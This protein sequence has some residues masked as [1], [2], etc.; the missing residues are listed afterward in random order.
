MSVLAL[1]NE[2]I[3]EYCTVNERMD[4]W[5]KYGLWMNQWVNESTSSCYSMSGSG[6]G[7]GACQFFDW[8][9]ATG[10]EGDLESFFSFYREACLLYFVDGVLYCCNCAAACALLTVL[11]HAFWN[12]LHGSCLSGWMQLGVLQRSLKSRIQGSNSIMWLGHTLRESTVHVWFQV[13]G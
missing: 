7:C 2:G 5:T 10:S 1:W 12:H 3:D 9:T 13:P 8:A 4:G 11:L 6:C